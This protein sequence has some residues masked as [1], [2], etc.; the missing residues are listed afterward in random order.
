MLR[1]KFFFY[2]LKS[3][4]LHLIIK[5]IMHRIPIKSFLIYFFF[6]IKV[7]YSQVTT[8]FSS[9][10][11]IGELSDNSFSNN[12]GMGG[13][14]ISN[15]SY[16]HLNNQNPAALVYNRFTT[17]EMGIASD[18][19]QLV[20]NET[21]DISGNGN[22]NYMGFGVPIIKGGKWVSSF[23][24]N[25][26]SNTNYKL[27]S[28][29]LILG[30]DGSLTSS[31]VNYNYD[32]NGGLS[33]VYF[34]NGFKL[35]DEFSIGFKGSYIFGNLSSNISS[36]VSNEPQFYSNLYEK[37]S[38]KDFAFQMGMFYRKEV[39]TDKYLKIGLTYDFNNSLEAKRFSQLERR[40]PNSL[41]VL[42]IDT[43]FNND[44]SQFTL[45]IKFGIGISYE[46]IDKL[47]LGLEIRSQQWNEESGYANTDYKKSLQISAGIEIIPD[48][49][50]VN[51]F[52]RRVTYRGGLLFKK[53]PLIINNNQLNTSAIT[54]GMSLPI[55][56][57]SRVNFGI[58]SGKRGNLNKI[59]IK[60]NYLKF[61]I[62]SS[63][64]NI[65]FIKRKFD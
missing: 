65:W 23:G 47:S 46:I 21:K 42:V 61:I 39:N 50:N 28:E 51:S 34:S 8:P 15:G 49:E 2:D 29:E 22:I 11:P 9:L 64:N 33:Q 7:S 10:I 48:A 45:P 63:I 60:E 62:G 37:S 53:S 27:F 41:T 13:V 38:F 17:F 1:I 4:S 56:T 40:I 44:I 19:R 6:L 5:L 35:G 52:F 30:V 36:K 26:Y 57:I 58:E 59:S 14:G 20:N 54:F 43:I 18:V 16:W 31:I 55:G 24:F 32:G 3:A 12:L 25:P